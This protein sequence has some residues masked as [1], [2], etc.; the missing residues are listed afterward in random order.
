MVEQQK[1]KG[2]EGR[3]CVRALCAVEVHWLTKK[4][5]GRPASEEGGMDDC[6]DGQY[7]GR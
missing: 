4:P 5:M 1:G 2:S 6:G 3:W 7:Q